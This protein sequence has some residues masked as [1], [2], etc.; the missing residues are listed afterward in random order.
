MINFNP[1]PLQNSL[2]SSSSDY[3]WT[4]RVQEGRILADKEMNG[5]ATYSSSGMYTWT[6][7]VQKA[8]GPVSY[9]WHKK[10]QGSSSWQLVGNNSSL[11]L[12]LTPSDG[13]FQLRVTVNDGFDSNEAFKFVD[14]VHDGGDCPP[15][16]I[17]ID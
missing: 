4:E 13:S 9:S 11:S 16:E 12:N 3:N 7:T 15:F 1:P 6:T 8:D 10:P 5:P 14:Y 2:T 17:C